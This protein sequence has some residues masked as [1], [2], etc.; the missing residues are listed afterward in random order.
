LTGSTTLNAVPTVRGVANKALYDPSNPATAFA[1]FNRLGVVSVAVSA[2][3][4]T[5]SARTNAL[6]PAGYH[7]R[8]HPWPSPSTITTVPAAKS[9]TL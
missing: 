1:A 4:A 9:A 7:T 2:V 6:S 3:T 5:S 8:D